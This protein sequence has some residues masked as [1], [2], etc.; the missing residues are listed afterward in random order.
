MSRVKA[1]H[2]L[3]NKSPIYPCLSLVSKSKE[4]SDFHAFNVPEKGPGMGIIIS[5][6]QKYGLKVCH[7]RKRGVKEE[8][9]TGFVQKSFHTIYTLLTGV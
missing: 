3:D 1:G 7:L 9:M 8:T 2:V 4:D 5:V 6:H